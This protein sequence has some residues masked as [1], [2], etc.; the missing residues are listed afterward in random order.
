MKV[1]DIFSKREKR[2]R[3]EVHDV[4]K[5]EDIPEE[6]RNQVILIWEDVFGAT[7]P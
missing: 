1:F 5:H 2:R 3:G 4:Y 6:L 7:Y